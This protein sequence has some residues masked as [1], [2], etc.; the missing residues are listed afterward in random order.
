MMI[1]MIPVAPN[2]D[3]SPVQ[4]PVPDPFVLCEPE[5]VGKLATET[6]SGLAD[7]AV[8]L[9]PVAT[10]CSTVCGADTVTGSPS[11]DA[12]KRIKI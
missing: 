2:E 9:S 3:C 12:G 7:A 6:G 1:E 8:E 11:P 10:S 5:I 4:A